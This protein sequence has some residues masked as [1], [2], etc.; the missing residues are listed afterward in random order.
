MREHEI[1]ML[2][3]FRVD[4]LDSGVRLV[5]VPCFCRSG[6]SFP[7]DSMGILFVH[8]HLL[9]QPISK[10]QP[11]LKQPVIDRKGLNEAKPRPIN[12]VAF[13]NFKLK[14]CCKF[15]HFFGSMRHQL[16]QP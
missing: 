15:I 10:E 14:K 12:D 2:Q 16:G 9:D 5:D 4:G 3:R 7:H 13:F 8:L 11:R 1:S 6:S